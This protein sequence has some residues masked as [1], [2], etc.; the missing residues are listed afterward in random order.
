[1]ATKPAAASKRDG[2]VNLIEDE[3]ELTRWKIVAA[4]KGLSLSAWIRM[5]CRI[6][7]G[8]PPEAERDG[9]THGGKKR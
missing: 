6:A 8:H 1:M 5:V 2:R 7:A 9:V 3:D 4:S